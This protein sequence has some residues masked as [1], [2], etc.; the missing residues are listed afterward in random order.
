MKKTLTSVVLLAGAVG[1]YAQFGPPE[2]ID[3][4]DT[5]AGLYGDAAGTVDLNW[6][7][8]LG[9]LVGGSGVNGTGG[10]APGGAVNGN[11]YLVP[12]SQGTPPFP[13][14]L[15][16]STT[17]SWDSY[18]TPLYTGQDLTGLNYQYQIAFRA[19][20][21]GSD[22]ISWASDNGST[23]YLNGV[24]LATLPSQGSDGSFSTPIA[25]SLTSN[26]VYT[27]DVVVNNDPTGGF[28]NPTGVNVELAG[29]IQ[30]STVPEP[31]SFALMLSGGCVALGAVR[32]KFS[33][34][35]F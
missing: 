10:P 31:S 33:R 1:A 6:T 35:N 19:D 16:N 15:P 3:N 27:V 29:P 8:A 25:L 34:K 11:A 4:F 23:A 24:A 5:G 7:V 21:T 9:G 20:G 17:S 30:V 13:N 26:S 28:V 22:S 14:W 18:S 32:R 2:N 12:N